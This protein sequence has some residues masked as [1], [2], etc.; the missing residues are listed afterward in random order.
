MLNPFRLE[1]SGDRTAVFSVIQSTETRGL[2]ALDHVPPAA[3]RGYRKHMTDSPY[4]KYTKLSGE[5]APKTSPIMRFDGALRPKE[6]LAAPARSSTHRPTHHRGPHA[7]CNIQCKTQSMRRPTEEAATTS[8]I[9]PYHR[10]Q[11][12]ARP[13]PQSQ[14]CTL[15]LEGERP[16]SATS[17]VQ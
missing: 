1:V 2:S 3:G 10:E 16:R 13:F 7:S 12:Q 9:T 11:Q 14:R 8:P 6:C 17:S 4:C 15:T 5:L